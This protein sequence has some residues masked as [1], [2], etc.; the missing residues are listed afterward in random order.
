[1][2][3]TA[4]LATASSLGASDLWIHVRVTEE[5]RRATTVEVNLPLRLVERLAPL[6]DARG[7]RD[8]RICLGTTPMD[9]AEL[10]AKWQRLSAGEVLVEDDAVLMMQAGARGRELVVRGRDRRDETVVTLPANVIDALL[11]GERDRLNLEAGVKALAAYGGGEIVAVQDD[12]AR[13]RIWLDRNPDG[14]D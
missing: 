2:I 1:M 5:G 7:K 14:S 9:V 6:V 12:G 11:S 3:L 10:R 8:A 4:L 13:V